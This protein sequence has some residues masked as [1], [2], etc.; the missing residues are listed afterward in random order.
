MRGKEIQPET[1]GVFLLEFCYSFIYWKITEIIS[2]ILF[3]FAKL[4]EGFA[5]LIY[6]HLTEEL[7]VLISDIFNF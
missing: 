7:L 5:Y 1:L 4:K 6:N 3:L 2:G